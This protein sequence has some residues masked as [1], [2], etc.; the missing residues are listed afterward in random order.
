MG[1]DKS[2]SNIAYVENG[3]LLAFAA[4]NP[5]IMGEKAIE[6]VVELEN[7]K[8]LGGVTVDTGVSTVTKENVA[9]FK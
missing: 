7:G 6:A 5:N 2:D 4:Q 9:Q 3:A 1:W 8:D